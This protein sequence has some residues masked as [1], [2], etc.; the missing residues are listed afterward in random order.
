MSNPR[1]QNVRGLTNARLVH[2]CGL[3][4]EQPKPDAHIALFIARVRERTSRILY[5]P[6]PAFLAPLGWIL[7]LQ[8]FAISTIWYISVRQVNRSSVDAPSLTDLR[9]VADNAY[10]NRSRHL[11]A[12]YSSHIPQVTLHSKPVAFNSDG[13]A[14]PSLQPI[15]IGSHS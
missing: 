13:I 14:C 2:D 12:I 8:V 6:R 9:V 11:R 3:Q 1:P 7:T 10:K 15:I 4:T 5:G